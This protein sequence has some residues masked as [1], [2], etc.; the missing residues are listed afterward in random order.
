M[1]HVF[2]NLLFVRAKE[3]MGFLLSKLSWTPAEPPD[4]DVVEPKTGLTPRQKQIVKDTWEI[5]KL[6]VKANG[7]ELFIKYFQEHP[8][9]QKFFRAFS[10]VPLSELRGNRRLLAHATSVMYAITSV[11]DN[12]DDPDCLIELLAKIGVSHIPRNLARHHFEHLSLTILE[13]LEEKLGSR[14]MN[15]TAKDAWR[16]T[17]DI[18]NSIIVENLE[19]SSRTAEEKSSSN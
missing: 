18:M 9:Y 17:L 7:V 6:D 11:V 19:K 16:K 14:I 13:L 2:S 5:V 8:E 10:D 12:L 1:D 4:Y 15:D 3:S